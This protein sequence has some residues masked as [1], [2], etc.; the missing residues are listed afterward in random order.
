[1]T[2]ANL[3]A[4]VASTAA[5]KGAGLV[6][7]LASTVKAFLDNVSLAGSATGAA[8]VGFL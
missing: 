8:L 7:Y 1:L 6:G 3:R 5:G 4:D 2:D